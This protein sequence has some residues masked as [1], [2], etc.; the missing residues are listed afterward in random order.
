MYKNKVL[1]VEDHMLFRKGLRFL[2]DNSD[3]FEVIGEAT[4]GLEGVKMMQQLNPDVVLL[5]ID[6]PAMQGIEALALM[7][8]HQ[9]ELAVIM[10]TVSEDS[11]DLT[12]AMRLG[13]RGY[14]LKNID[15]QFLLQS[16]H[17]ALEGDSV[18]SPEMTSKLIQ[19]FRQPTTKEPDELFETLTPREK[20]ILLILV[21]GGSNKMIA[22]DLD[23]TE[24]TVK[25][26]V[27]NILRKL[28]LSSRVQAAVYAIEHG[29]VISPYKKY[30]TI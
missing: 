24:S 23:V 27:Q 18:L 14:L 25:V 6:M 20:E 19:Q 30:S 13:A 12:E 28:N 17:K 1:L 22:R 3:D 7:L 9:P 21:Q 16:I 5:D 15:T 4:D 26:H 11:Y 10:L 29:L 2:I 8:N